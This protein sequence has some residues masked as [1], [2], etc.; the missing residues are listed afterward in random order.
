MITIWRSSCF[1]HQ[2]TGKF[3]F[4]LES[5]YEDAS[6]TEWVV[7]KRMKS[8]ARQDSGL[9]MKEEPLNVFFTYKLASLRKQDGTLL[10]ELE[11][12]LVKSEPLEDLICR[13]RQL[14]G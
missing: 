3:V 2:R 12:A 9:A 10:S 11:E 13:F 14:S 5:E 1:R 8:T 4:I 6:A 7:S